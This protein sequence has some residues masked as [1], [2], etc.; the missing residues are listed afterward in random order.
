[1]LEKLFDWVSFVALSVSGFYILF[2][3]T[4][5]RGVA[6]G[7]ILVIYGG[8]S[9]VHTRLE[10]ELSDLRKDVAKIAENLRVDRGNG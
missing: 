8:L 4:S 2:E 7:S 3:N 1:M 5:S 10:Q 9:F 6:F